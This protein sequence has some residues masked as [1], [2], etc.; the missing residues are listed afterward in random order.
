MDGIVL[1]LEEVALL[2]LRE[3]AD[4]KFAALISR[5]GLFHSKEFTRSLMASA[6]W[7]LIRPCLR[8]RRLFFVSRHV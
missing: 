1:P 8:L 5:V 7:Y 6:P 3:A 4:V 2:P